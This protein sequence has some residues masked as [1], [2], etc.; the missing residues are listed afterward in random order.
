M[1]REEI[2]YFQNEIDWLRRGGELEVYDQHEECWYKDD[3]PRFETTQKIVICDSMEKYR[4]AFELKKEV[5]VRSKIL[6]QNWRRLRDRKLF[7]THYEYTIKEESIIEKV[8][9]WLQQH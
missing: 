4:K 8:K 7:E 6:K 5:Y 1:N 9:Q 3:N 2:I